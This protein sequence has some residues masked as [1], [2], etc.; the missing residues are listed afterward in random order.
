MAGRGKSFAPSGQASWWIVVIA[1]TI[2]VI[3]SVAIIRELVQSH[4]VRQQVKALREQVA[5][6]QQRQQEYRDL[7]E[8]LSSPTFQEREARLKLGLK[9]PGE[10]VIVIPSLDSNTNSNDVNSSTQSGPAAS[11]STVQRWWDFF[12][13]ARTNS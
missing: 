12:F 9:K 3:F 11:Q 5:T 10:R 6:E 8:Y 13:A 1:S 4:Q 2:L 7:I